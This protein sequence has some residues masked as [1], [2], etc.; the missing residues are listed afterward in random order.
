MTIGSYHAKTHLPGLLDRVAKGERITITKHGVPVAVLM[1]PPA[2]RP[3]SPAT[4]LAEM[5]AFRKGRKLGKLSIR[6]MI[7]EGRRF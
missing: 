6:S 3:L 5:K 4:A 7:E 2:A 1:P